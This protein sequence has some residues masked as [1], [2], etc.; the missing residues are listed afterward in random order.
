MIRIDTVPMGAVRM[1]QRGKWTSDSAKRYLDYKHTIAWQIRANYRDGPTD[2][3]VGVEI[4]F[5][6]PIPKSWSRKKQQEAIGKPHQV[7]PD[8]DNLVKGC[9]DAANGLIWKDDALVVDCKAKKIYSESP[10]IE[11]SWKELF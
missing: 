4:T 9:F 10:G 3:A 1:T 11:I 5:H 7:K 2:C 6:M 8:I